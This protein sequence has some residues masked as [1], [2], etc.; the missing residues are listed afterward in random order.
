VAQIGVR[1]VLADSGIALAGDVAELV[2]EYRF[3][4]NDELAKAV[5]GMCGYDVAETGALD[6]PRRNVLSIQAVR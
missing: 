6:V 5:S 4:F 2:R 3:A 1:W